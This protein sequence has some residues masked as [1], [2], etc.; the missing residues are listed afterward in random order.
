MAIQKR[1]PSKKKPYINHQ[2]F[3]NIP[4]TPGKKVAYFKQPVKQREV[5]DSPRQPFDPLSK[6]NRQQSKHPSRDGWR[7]S[8]AQKEK[9]TS[10]IYP[11]AK[12]S[13]AEPDF[14]EGQKGKSET[15]PE[16][17]E[18]L[19]SAEGAES[20]AVETEPAKQATAPVTMKQ[21]A[22]MLQSKSFVQTKSNNQVILAN[23]AY[24]DQVD[25]SLIQVSVLEEIWDVD[26]VQPFEVVWNQDWEEIQSEIK[27]HVQDVRQDYQ[28]K[29][30]WIRGDLELTAKGTL[31]QDRKLV[32]ETL[33]FPFTSTI[34]HPA[35][36]KRSKETKASGEHE[37]APLNEKWIETGEWRAM[38]LSDP[39][40]HF[41][42]GAG[43][44]N[45]LAS[46]SGRIW[47]FR[48]QLIPVHMINRMQ[49]SL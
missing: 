19:P 39:F 6:K 22:P 12:Y 29:I 46:I 34:L 31:A 5:D 44:Y 43:V 4:I 3:Q 2:G 14:V 45:G 16:Q 18:H 40:H 23:V 21:E 38:L 33:C 27:I 7:K 10:S 30:V 20:V 15:L 25:A 42:S 36:S 35:I 11:I 9:K 37:P 49:G 26:W 28:K 17:N 13:L 8:Q 47:W 1:T 48:K 24:T 32:Y 41:S